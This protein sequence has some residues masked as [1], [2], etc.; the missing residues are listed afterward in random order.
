MGML[1]G[2]LLGI[3]IGALSTKV[4]KGITIRGFYALAVLAGFTNRL[5]ALPGKLAELEVIAL[6]MPI[7][8]VLDKIG[9]WAFFVVIGIFSVWVIGTF[10]LNLRTL[11][12]EGPSHAG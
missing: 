8:R 11:K 3:Q 10:L 7:L 9:I 1:I 5:F 2:S 6:P 4:V 12:G